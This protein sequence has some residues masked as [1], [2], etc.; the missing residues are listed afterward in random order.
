MSGT[1]CQCIECHWLMCLGIRVLGGIFV[2]GC[3]AMTFSHWR[4]VPRSIMTRL[5]QISNLKIPNLTSFIIRYSQISITVLIADS[6]WNLLSSSLNHSQYFAVLYTTCLC[7][8][9]SG[10]YIITENEIGVECW[11]RINKPN[12]ISQLLTCCIIICL[13]DKRN[14]SSTWE[15][16]FS[17]C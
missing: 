10:R 6:N 1:K 17:T 2:L 3:W 16:Y 8:Q 15:L 12:I 9:T 11:N 13:G 14:L 7:V 5:S 4:F